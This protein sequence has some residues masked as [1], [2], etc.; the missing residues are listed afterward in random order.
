MRTLQVRSGFPTL[1]TLKEN[2]ADRLFPPILEPPSFTREPA[3]TEVV[4][5]SS[6][7]F[8]GLL[9]GTG[10]FEVT[11]HKDAKEIKPS[12]K[13]GFSQVNGS[14]GLEVHKCDTV[15]VGE[16]QCTVTNE[17]GSCTC[18]TTLNLKGRSQQNHV[19]ILR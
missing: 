3:P 15:D 2:I 9:A 6:A 13:H 8:E 16:Y 5:G 17:V 4:K 14:V 7:G 1:E 10:P 19:L 11:W 18:K 12:A